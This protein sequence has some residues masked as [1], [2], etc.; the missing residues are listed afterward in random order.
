MFKNIISS[1]FLFN[2]VLKY[3]RIEVQLRTE[4]FVVNMI[5]QNQAGNN[6]FKRGYN[7]GVYIAFL[8]LILPL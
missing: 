5:Y 1:I 2:I 8:G 4:R 3:A 6:D 7:T